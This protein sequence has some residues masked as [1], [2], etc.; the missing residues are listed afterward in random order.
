VLFYW[1]VVIL[2]QWWLIDVDFT[3]SKLI[4]S[5]FTDLFDFVQS[6]RKSI[7]PTGVLFVD[8]TDRQTHRQHIMLAG[9]A[10]SST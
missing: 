10:N 6:Y 4:D 1:L 5:N 3:D 2:V 8:F 9:V 7:S